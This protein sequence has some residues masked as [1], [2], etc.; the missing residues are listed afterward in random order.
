MD[1]YGGC[2]NIV[3]GATGLGTTDITYTYDPLY[4]LTSANY[5]GAY[6]Y[7]FTHAHDNVGSRTA[8][9]RTI[10][11]MLVTTY[12]YNSANRL[13]NAGGVPYA[14]NASGNLLNHGGAM[15]AYD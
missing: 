15:Y 13:I 2:G 9:T 7:T 5:T 10:A 12:T 3:S 14:S 1:R 11:S 4:R 8:Y 6:T